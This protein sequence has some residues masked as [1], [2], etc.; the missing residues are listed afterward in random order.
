MSWKTKSSYP[1]LPNVLNTR[2][3]PPVLEPESPWENGYVESLNGKRR[4]ELLD[5]DAFYSVKEVRILIKMWRKEYNTA[6]P[7]SSLWLSA[8]GDWF[9]FSWAG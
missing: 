8:T 3:Y 7:R 6:R 4:D 5:Q 2:L 9:R 1:S